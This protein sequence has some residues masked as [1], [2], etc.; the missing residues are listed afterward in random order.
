MLGRVVRT[1]AVAALVVACAADELPEESAPE[2]F[3]QGMCH[4]GRRCGFVSNS[5]TCTNSCVVDRP[6]LE[7]LSRDGAQLLGDCIGELA[8]GELESPAWEEAFQR[9]WDRARVRVPPTAGLR[10]FCAEFA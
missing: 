3:C 4:A 7:H 8:C 1:L 5:I 6:G 10:S 9:C 2:L